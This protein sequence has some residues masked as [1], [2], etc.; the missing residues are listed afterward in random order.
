MEGEG[1]FSQVV[2]PLFDDNSYDLWTIRMQTCLE[3]QH[4]WEV[5][6]TCIT[7]L[8]K[9]KRFVYNYFDRSDTCLTSTRETKINEKILLFKVLCFILSK[10]LSNSRTTK[11]ADTKTVTHVFPS[12][13]YCK[14]KIINTTRVDRTKCKMSPLWSI[15]ACRKNMQI[16]TSA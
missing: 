3:G 11:G 6:G 15:G 9:H 4:L 10:V 5:V 14:K 12:C 16:P 13:P 1:N 8:E 7:L 2:I